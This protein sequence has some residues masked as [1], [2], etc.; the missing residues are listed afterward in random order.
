MALE[1]HEAVLACAKSLENFANRWKD[2][3]IL[4]ETFDLLTRTVS[5]NPSVA[6]GF[7]VDIPSL[8]RLKE[9]LELLKM[10]HHNKSV[11]AMIE[12]MVYMPC[13]TED[14]TYSFDADWAFDLL[15]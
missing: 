9:C 7:W 2:A 3:A 8:M 6:G 10:Q 1:T 4:A 11:V 14:D 5:W 13:R 15:N 12:D